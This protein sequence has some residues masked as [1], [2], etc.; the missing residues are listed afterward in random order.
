M[1]AILQK[2]IPTLAGVKPENA[3]NFTRAANFFARMLMESCPED[4]FGNTHNPLHSREE[5][6]KLIQTIPWQEANP[7]IAKNLGKLITAAGSLVHGLYNDV[8]TDFGWDA[9]GPYNIS[10]PGKNYQ[11]IIRH[12]PDL[13]PLDLWPERSLTPLQDL[14]ILQF[15]E[16]TEWELAF[17]GCHTVL[18]SGDPIAGLKNYAVVANGKYLKPEA[19]TPI[20]NELAEKASGLYKHLRTTNFE[21]LKEMVMLQECYQLIKIFA[22]AYMN[23]LPTDELNARIKGK[24]LLKNILPHGKLMVDLEEYKELFH[25]NSFAS[26]L[27]EHHNQKTS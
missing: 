11:V 2:I 6:N 8:V 25:L 9:Y 22:A 19:I 20:V 18:K 21:E 24:Q 10:V 14:K 12:F 26:A 15:Y 4:A 7:E 3:K 1:R 16:N 17:L 27:N 13:A 23:W 5:I